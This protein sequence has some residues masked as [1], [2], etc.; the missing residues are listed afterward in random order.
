M[1]SKKQIGHSK[2]FRYSDRYFKQSGEKLC[3][4]LSNES[5]LQQTMQM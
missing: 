1:H 5:I 3:D 4:K 2:R